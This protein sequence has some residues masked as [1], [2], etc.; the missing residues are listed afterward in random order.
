MAVSWCKCLFGSNIISRLW[1]CNSWI[2]DWPFHASIFLSHFKLRSVKSHCIPVENQY[3][4]RQLS[5]ISSIVVLRLI[6]IKY[7]HVLETLRK[8]CQSHGLSCNIYLQFFAYPIIY[9]SFILIHGDRTSRLIV[10]FVHVCMAMVFIPW[11]GHCYLITVCSNCIAIYYL[12]RCYMHPHLMT[13]NLV[14]PSML[15]MTSSFHN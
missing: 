7:C 4:L 13:S 3:I 2:L 11:T 5:T 9:F 14:N 10:S 1:S 15:T 12:K 6:I 8:S